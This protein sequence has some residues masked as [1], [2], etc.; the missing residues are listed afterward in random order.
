MEATM[1][2]GSKQTFTYRKF[3]DIGML[4]AAALFWVA[5]LAFVFVM[6]GMA[7]VLVGLAVLAM[8][9]YDRI[10]GNHPPRPN[11]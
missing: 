11:L 7:F 6:M 9:A 10:R 4:V 2:P 8:Y 1:H 3:L 5:V